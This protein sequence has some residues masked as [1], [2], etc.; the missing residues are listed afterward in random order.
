MRAGVLSRCEHGR[1]GF[2]MKRK[3]YLLEAQ[4]LIRVVASFD[5]N[6]ESMVKRIDRRGS[7]RQED[8]PLKN[9]SAHLIKDEDT[10]RYLR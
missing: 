9:L 7:I 2:Q 5:G 1:L 4:L 3:G 6:N 10:F 8:C